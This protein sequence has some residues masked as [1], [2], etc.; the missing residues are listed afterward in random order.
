MG[1]GASK[2]G[3]SGGAMSEAEKEKK[4]LESMS[5]YSQTAMRATD[6]KPGDTIDADYRDENGKKVWRQWTYYPEGYDSFKAN[7][8]SDIK[9]TSVKV[10]GKQ[11][12]VEGLFDK[13]VTKRNPKPEDYGKD[14]IKVKRTFKKDDIILKRIPKDQRK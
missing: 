3:R 12:K 7:P 6:I 14:F 2:A 13:G 10:T 8:M 1:R 11:V 4:Y 9:I 5:N